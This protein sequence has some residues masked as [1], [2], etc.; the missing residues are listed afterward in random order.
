MPRRGKWE[1]LFLSA[2]ANL[3]NSRC[4]CFSLIPPLWYNSRMHGKHWA[5]RIRSPSREAGLVEKRQPRCSLGKHHQQTQ[6]THWV[7]HH[8]HARAH[9]GT[10][11]RHAFAHKHRMQYTS[12]TDNP[13][14]VCASDASVLGG[15]LQHECTASA[16][17]NF[18][19]SL[20]LYALVEDSRRRDKPDKMENKG[21][22]Q[23]WIQVLPRAGGQTKQ[24]HWSAID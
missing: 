9:T 12:R 13:R 16:Q 20:T 8:A 3:V 18:T 4:T 1:G 5:V 7:I 2:S 10:H 19:H 6:D 21:Q 23:I 15:F 17:V 22:C 14:G 24:R 11:V